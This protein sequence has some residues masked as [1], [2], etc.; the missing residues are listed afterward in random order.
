MKPI[1][2]LSVIVLLCVRPAMGEPSKVKDFDDEKRSIRE[3]LAVVRERMAS[4]E[5]E[6]VIFPTGR[7]RFP[8]AT[9]KEPEDGRTTGISGEQ[10]YSFGDAR[11]L[12]NIESWILEENVKWVFIRLDVDIPSKHFFTLEKLLS[13]KDVSYILSPQDYDVANGLMEERKSGG[14]L[15]QFGDFVNGMMRL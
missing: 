5:K 8:V 7:F 13:E 11:Y 10:K 14:P 9:G 6:A 4:G 1:L 15:D 2:L 3:M 12:S